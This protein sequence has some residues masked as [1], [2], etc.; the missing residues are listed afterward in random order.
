MSPTF[1]PPPTDM[2]DAA[3]SFFHDPVRRGGL[4]N[5]KPSSNLARSL[6]GVSSR[7]YGPNYDPVGEPV[8]AYTL[9]GK[10]QSS[11]DVVPPH[12]FMAGELEDYIGNLEHGNSEVETEELNFGLLSPS[13]P[14]LRPAFQA[15]ELI[16]YG[17]IMEHGDEE[18]EIEEQGFMPHYFFTPQG[19]QELPTISMSPGHMYP[20]SQRLELN[21]RYPFLSGERPPGTMLHFHSDFETGGDHWDEVHYE[22]YHYP[23]P[24]H[25]EHPMKNQKV[26]SDDLW[27]QPQRFIKAWPKHYM[28]H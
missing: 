19:V 28:Q 8:P 24:E 11:D 6:P 21:M 20:F 7:N 5:T 27:Q 3:V 26:P 2:I 15:G 13:H 12:S 22:R 9:S 18:R 10:S 17:S 14:Y 16:E 23:K 1:R 4:T 25:E